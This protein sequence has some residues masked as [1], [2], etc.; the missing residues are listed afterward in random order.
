MIAP[1]IISRDQL[2]GSTLEHPRATD[3]RRTCDRSIRLD[4]R[5]YRCERETR[6]TDGTHDGIHDAF[7]EHH[8]GGAARW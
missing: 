2:R 3:P 8:D 1:R 7:T 5:T 4:N 6:S